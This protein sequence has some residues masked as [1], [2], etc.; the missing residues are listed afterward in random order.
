MGICPSPSSHFTTPFPS[1]SFLIVLLLW[2]AAWSIFAVTEEPTSSTFTRFAPPGFSP[3]SLPPPSSFLTTLPPAAFFS[4]APAPPSSFLTTAAAAALLRR[5]TVSSSSSRCRRHRSSR[6]WASTLCRF[7]RIVSCGNQPMLNRPVPL[8]STTRLVM[9]KPSLR[10]VSAYCMTK[11]P[12]SQS[13]VCRGMDLGEKAGRVLASKGMSRL[14]AAE[15]CFHTDSQNRRKVLK[16]PRESWH[17]AESS[18]S[19]QGCGSSAPNP[20]KGP[21]AAAARPPPL[22]LLWASSSPLAPAASD[23][24]P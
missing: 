4:A 24:P 21:A 19:R 20:A 13:L 11:N 22:P 8:A 12:Q 2:S 15:E 23:P 3:S 9:G 7:R 18:S 17:L 6:T 16:H 1:S 10:S 5:A 14:P